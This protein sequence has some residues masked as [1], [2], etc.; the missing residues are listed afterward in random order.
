MGTQQD[1]FVGPGRSFQESAIAAGPSGS[2][3]VAFS[4]LDNLFLRM[5]VSG[6]D[7]TTGLSYSFD[8]PSVSE[9]QNINVTVG[10]RTAPSIAFG[11][12]RYLVVW[13]EWSSATNLDIYGQFLSTAGTSIG[14][15]FLINDAS[16]AEV[17]DERRPDVVHLGN[18]NFAVMWDGF[19]TL[20]GY[21]IDGSGGRASTSL[22]YSQLGSIPTKPDLAANQDGLFYSVFS[23]FNRSH[24]GSYAAFLRGHASEGNVAF[25]TQITEL[26]NVQEPVVT[27]LVNGSV[28]VIWRDQSL[29]SSDTSGL[30]VRGRI[31]TGL[32]TPSGDEFIISETVIGNQQS[33]EVTALSDGGFAVVWA[34]PVA[35]AVKIRTFDQQGLATSNET[36]VNLSSSYDQLEPQIAEL[37]DGRLVVTWIEDQSTQVLKLRPVSLESFDVVPSISISDAMVPEGD[38]FNGVASFT[39]SLSSATSADVTVSYENQ[40]GTALSGVDFIATSGVLTIPAGQ[41]SAVVSVTVLGDVLVEPSETFTLVFSN[42]SGATFNGGGSSLQ[43]T[44]TVVDNDGYVWN[45]QA[46]LDANPDLVAAGLTT[47]GALS[48]WVS[49]GYREGRSLFFDTAAYITANPDLGRAGLTQPQAL[50]HY[51]VFGKNENRPLSASDYLN[52]NPDLIS[53]GFNDALAGEHYAEFGRNEGRSAGFDAAGYLVM[54]PDLISAGLTVPQLIQHYTAYGR[55]EGRAIFNPG[56]YIAAN[57][58]LGTAGV[59]VYL[60]YQEIGR[61]EGRNLTPISPSAL[62]ADL[63]GVVSV[64]DLLA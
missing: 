19:S 54:N 6:T 64:F 10:Q 35:N 32:G 3:A 11:T 38:S 59:D 30:A 5:G 45:A 42:P 22:S 60:H 37:T 26:A 47:D 50:E 23:E 16:T 17:D 18:N 55:N 15:A 61:S 53:A 28:V 52:A 1:V 58:D 31:F 63:I 14:N 57:P 36:T 24:A 4:F 20:S 12:D 8:L 33:P 9:N 62:E 27:S 48:H 7:V 34:D 25:S 43:A 56:S 39:V 40:S 46:Y 49:N 29:T 13:Q 41:T 51:Q 2:Y 44:G 21:V